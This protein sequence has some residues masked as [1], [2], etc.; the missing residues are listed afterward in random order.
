MSGGARM[1]SGAFRRG[2]GG[3]GRRGGWG[4]G[5]RWGRG[6]GRGWG[7]WGGWW[8]GWP[9]YVIYDYGCSECWGLP[10]DEY[11]YC[12]TVYGCA[13]PMLGLGQETTVSPAVRETVSRTAGA[14]AGTVAGGVIGLGLGVAGLGLLAYYAFKK[15]PRQNRRRR[16]R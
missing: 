1:G 11:E 14:V 4:R 6:R 10:P 9:S 16:S 7:G 15:S 2:R 13:H 3:R 8:G 5:R 12:M